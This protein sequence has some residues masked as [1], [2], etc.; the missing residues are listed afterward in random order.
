MV[1]TLASTIVGDGLNVFREGFI[2]DKYQARLDDLVGLY[3]TELHGVENGYF[4]IS[5]FK[6]GRLSALM[7]RQI[8]AIY[9]DATEE[10]RYLIL[11]GGNGLNA[12]IGPIFAQAF[13]LGGLSM[14]DRVIDAVNQRLFVAG[15]EFGLSPGAAC[16]ED[17]KGNAEALTIGY[18]RL[19]GGQPFMVYWYP[20]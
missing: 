5:R 19:D 10:L 4:L 14:L 2:E 6:R 11:D 17:E 18:A 7:R 12:S 15:L 16:L 8:E 9:K 1:D 13:R 20:I 3:M